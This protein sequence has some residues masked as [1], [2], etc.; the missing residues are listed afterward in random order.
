MIRSLCQAAGMDDFL[1]KPC[2][3]TQLDAVLRRWLGAGE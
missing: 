1:A 3:I 2:E